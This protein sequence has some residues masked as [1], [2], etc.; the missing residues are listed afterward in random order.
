MRRRCL[1]FAVLAVLLGAG[2]VPHAGP[3][4]GG[5]LDTLVPPPEGAAAL[6]GFP[7]RPP[8]PPPG[9]QCGDN[10][11][12]PGQYCCNASCGTCANF[13]DYCTQQV[14]NPTS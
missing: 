7:A 1:L 12:G 14:C 6:A 13:G 11:C 2:V 4:P 8:F 5:D 9:G 3:D 10:V